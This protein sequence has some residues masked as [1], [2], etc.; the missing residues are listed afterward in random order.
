MEV[1]TAAV[2]VYGAVLSSF[3]AFLAWR[4]DR[5]RVHF[6]NGFVRGES[7]ARLEITVVNTGFRPVALASA[8]FETSDGGGYLP[9]PDEELGFP[10]KL[11][12]GDTLPLRFDSDDIWPETSA[13]V[14]RGHDGREHRHVF[15]RDFRR[16]WQG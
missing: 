7:G 6:S 4:K 10:C 12:E 14:V 1:A 9:T 16:E 3:L 2:A 11:S 13:F 5:R 8:H 15:D